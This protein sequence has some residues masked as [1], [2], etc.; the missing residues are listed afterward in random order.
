LKASTLVGIALLAPAFLVLRVVDSQ[1]VT[2]PSMA[3]TSG[4]VVILTP[5]FPI[6]SIVSGLMLGLAILVF[7]RKRNRVRVQSRS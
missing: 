1:T 3:T 5:G 4:F 2:Q 7:V 6:A